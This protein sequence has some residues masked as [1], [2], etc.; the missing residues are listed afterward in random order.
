VLWSPGDPSD[1]NPPVSYDV[2]EYTNLGNIPQDGANSTSDRW[3]LDGFVLSAVRTYEGA[4]SYYSGAVNQESHT[5]QATTFYTVTAETDTFTSR[6]WY[7][8]ETDWD[9]AYF[10]VSTTSGATWESVPGNL[11]TDYDP[12]GNNRGN[13]ITGSS[14]GW[15]EAIFPL[16][17]HIGNEIEIRFS[18]IT[19][20]SVL[21]E[22]IYVDLPGPVP[23][24]EEKTIVASEIT[25][26]LLAV[27]PDA[28]GNFTYRVRARDAENQA[29]LWSFSESIEITDVTGVGDTPL[30]ASRLGA[31][32][33]NP[34]NPVTTIPYTV[35]ESPG[36]GGMVKVRL[37]IYNVAGQPVATLVDGPAAPG[38]YRAEWN[39]RTRAGEPLS[40]G[41]YFARLVI[42]DEQRFT[43]KLVLLK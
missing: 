2:V 29:S 21:E 42:G 7:D 3:I 25:D 8:I 20:Q 38:V 32:Y 26:T 28:P 39:G 24:Y 15:V 41:V 17:E 10:E 22:G 5:L 14:G 31:N 30:L 4:G 18:Y 12:H 1:P 36:T 23:T 9:Y 34:F 37:R 27:T 33:P 13:G 11:T 35:G 19:D 6:V 43:R 40:S 16:T